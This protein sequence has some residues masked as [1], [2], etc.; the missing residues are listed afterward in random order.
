MIRW[1]DRKNPLI[2]E[3][4][5]FTPWGNQKRADVTLVRN[6]CKEGKYRQKTYSTKKENPARDKKT[7]NNPQWVLRVPI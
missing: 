7:P 2:T 6:S 3:S 4:E 5:V 1:K